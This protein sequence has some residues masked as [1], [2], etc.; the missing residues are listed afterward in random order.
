MT[1]ILTHLSAGYPYALQVTDRLVTKG[2][3]PFDPLANKNIVYVARNA[4][5]SIAY[6]GLAY[7]DGIPTDVWI[8]ERLV[9]GAPRLS[10]E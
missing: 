7:I 10:E 3:S 6:T 1:L 2:G 4:I 5:V 9:G 8:A